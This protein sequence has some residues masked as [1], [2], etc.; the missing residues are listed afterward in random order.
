MQTFMF[1]WKGNFLISQKEGDTGEKWG[2]RV[3][4]ISTFK[5]TNDRTSQLLTWIT[6]NGL[7][8]HQSWIYFSVQL[9]PNQSE[10]M[11]FNFAGSCATKGRQ[12][13]SLFYLCLSH[14]SFPSKYCLYSSAGSGSQLSEKSFTRKRDLLMLGQALRSSSPRLGWVLIGLLWSLHGCQ[15]LWGLRWSGERVGAVTPLMMAWH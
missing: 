6:T 14:M 12:I 10:L 13:I 11:V 7:Q 8:V 5:Q 15:L 3:F 2:K 1:C 4:D 9:P